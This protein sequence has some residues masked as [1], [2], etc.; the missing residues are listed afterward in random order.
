M[1]RAGQSR[2]PPSITPTT[3]IPTASQGTATNMMRTEGSTANQHSRGLPRVIDPLILSIIV[4]RA[5]ASPTH[6]VADLA[7]LEQGSTRL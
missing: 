6:S 5:S 3:P 7:L 1:K 4:T 2:V